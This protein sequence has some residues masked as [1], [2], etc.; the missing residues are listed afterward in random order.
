MQSI[1]VLL[2]STLLNNIPLNTTNKDLDLVESLPNYDYNGTLYSGYLKVSPKKQF[3]YMLNIHDED[4]ENKPLVLWLNGGPGC[5]S[6]D[7]WINENGPMILNKNGTF[8]R[9][10]YAWNKA[11]NM[12]YI[13]SPVEVGFS[14][15]VN[16]SYSDFYFND[17]I[18]AKDNFLALLNFFIKFPE[19]K[20]KEFYISGESYAGIYIPMLAYEIINYNKEV[21]DDNKI[22]LKGIMIGNGV[23]N[24]TLSN[25][26]YSLY[27]YYFTHHFA[28]YETRLEFNEYCYH[29]F[30]NKECNK[31]KSK[32]K[33]LT[34]NINRYNYL[35]E[36]ELP[37]MLDGEINYYSN[38][39]LKNSWA[40]PDLKEKQ[41][42]IKNKNKLFSEE[43]NEKL[44][45]EIPCFYDKHI[46]NY[47]NRNDVKKALHVKMDIKWDLCSF[48]VGYDYYKQ[49]KGSIWVIPKLIKNNLRI[50]IFNGDTDMVVPFNQ[51]LEWIE[52][53]KLDI[54]EPW[55]KWR[56]Y[57]DKNNIS[58]YVTKYKG[59][60]F[61][62][63]KGAGHEVPRWKPKESLY[64]LTQFLNNEK[65]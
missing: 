25:E 24:N 18:V 44:T 1:Y 19:Y 56:A 14:Y 23:V 47:F 53:L 9:N 42:L 20:G 37:T 21:P 17:D 28:S 7:G 36:C 38:Y 45:A 41:V 55:R 32:M 30:S 4:P 27:D 49:K 40:F 46:I 65:L 62:T 33:K 34:Q 61:C 29:N 2:I 16:Q 51:N 26:G 10:E 13:E 22:N 54:E 3:H 11:A 39:Y 63:I 64:M 59:L 58:G 60:T 35:E 43:N 5:S 31:V 6:L 12:L 52:S 8:K 15:F 50:L 48:W 57:G